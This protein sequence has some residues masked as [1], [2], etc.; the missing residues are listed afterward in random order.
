[1]NQKAQEKLLNYSWPGNIRELRHTMEKAVIL[2]ESAV[3]TPEDFFL[4]SKVTPPLANDLMTLE[5]MEKRM[6][7]SSLERTVG[8]LTK[9]AEELGITRQ[10]IYNK[11][12]KY[13]L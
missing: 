4:K 5:E 8:N 13:G 6:I 1:M 2:N 7:L 11:V 12:R 10:T 3:L 9:S